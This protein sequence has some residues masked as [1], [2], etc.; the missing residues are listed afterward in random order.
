MSNILK[1]SVDIETVSLDND[2]G[3]LSIGAIV[4]DTPWTQAY[5][6]FYEKVD[7][8]SLEPLGFHLSKATLDWWSLQNRAVRE[9]SFSGTK[10]IK[11]VLTDFAIWIELE[12][13][14]AGVS[15]IEIYGNGATFD[16]V[17][18][19]NAF[20]RCD[21]RVPWTYR[22]DRCYRTVAALFPSLYEAA[23]ALVTN[24]EKH[25]ALEDARYQ[26][27][28]LSYIFKAIRAKGIIVCS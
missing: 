22:E 11:E 7:F 27:F 9:E 18:L 24:P 1:I 20:D 19:R 4:F 15:S 23:T 3:I 2:A 25:N 5:S 21:V 13:Q 14:K 10:H 17:V 6:N 28:I 8:K 16:N 26:G 12:K